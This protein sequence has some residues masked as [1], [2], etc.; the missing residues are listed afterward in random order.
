MSERQLYKTDLGNQT[1]RAKNMFRDRAEVDPERK[2]L[3]NI[4]GEFTG[5]AYGKKLTDGILGENAGTIPRLRV[6]MAL[7]IAAFRLLAKEKPS[8]RDVP[9]SV[10]LGWLVHQQLHDNLIKAGITEEHHPTRLSFARAWGKHAKAN[11]LRDHLLLPDA[12]LGED[13]PE[14]VLDIHAAGNAPEGPDGEPNVFG[15]QLRE[16]SP[17]GAV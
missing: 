14:E 13:K 4:V 15:D 17:E 11:G 9:E 1:L 7:S 10:H 16:L 8:K 2:H 3:R 5:E 12:E 6:N